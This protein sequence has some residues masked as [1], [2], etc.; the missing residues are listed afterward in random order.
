M[1]YNYLIYKYNQRMTNYK[2]S[3]KSVKT[4]N[5]KLIFKVI[6]SDSLDSLDS[7]DNFEEKDKNKYFSL[8][9]IIGW[10]IIDIRYKPKKIK[11]RKVISEN[12]ENI[13][14]KIEKSEKSETSEREKKRVRKYKYYIEIEMDDKER[15]KNPLKILNHY[16][17]KYKNKKGFLEGCKNYYKAVRY[18]LI[19]DMIYFLD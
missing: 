4:K 8:G 7:L 18:D 1:D 9:E 11:I 10:I 15:I 17:E 2:F 3:V 16:I 13:R 19:P 5:N 14:T 6:Q 12:I